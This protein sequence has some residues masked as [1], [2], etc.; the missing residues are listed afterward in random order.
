MGAARKRCGPYFFG[1]HMAAPTQAQIDQA[2]T[3]ALTSPKSTSGEQGEVVN[4]A[5][6][7]VIKLR[8]AASAARAA[9]YAGFGMRVQKLAPRYQ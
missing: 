9:N 8:N 3:D 4:N 6:D 1:Q 5:A 7:D 2:L